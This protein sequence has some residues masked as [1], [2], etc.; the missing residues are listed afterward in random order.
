MVIYIDTLIFTNVIIDYL[1]LCTTSLIV[2]KNYSVIRLLIS[3]FIGG[4]SSLYILVESFS[5]IID[6]LFKIIVGAVMIVVANGIKK[7]II[8]SFSVFLGLSFMLNG[9]VIFLSNLINSNV[10]YSDNFI[11]YLNISPILLIILTAIIYF[12]I[13]IV[14]RIFIRKTNVKTAKL[15]IKIG[16]FILSYIALI[17]SGNTL[18]DPFGNGQIFIL[19]C[20]EFSKI[21][22]LLDASELLKRSRVIPVKTISS[23]CLLDALRCDS[24]KITVNSDVFEYNNPIIASSTEQIENDFK[25]II[26]ISS[27]ERIS[28]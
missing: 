24:S 25:A 9:S 1:L 2:K 21:T 11:N 26:P 8:L 13:K 5:I 16:E 6:I 18:T 12:C 3:A 27:I 4:I 22:S 23:Q 17:D 19:S 15:S 14:Q 7:G 20:D 28:D 10:F